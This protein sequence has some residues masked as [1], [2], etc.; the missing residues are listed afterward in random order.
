MKLFYHVI[1]IGLALAGA[2]GFVSMRNKA[3]V[4]H[5]ENLRLRDELATQRAAGDDPAGP[6]AQRN[7][8]LERVQAEARE[9]HKLR[10]EISQLRAGAKEAEKVAMENQR[11]R[12]ATQQ[13][14]T[15]PRTGAAV[16]PAAASQEGFYAK[17]NW[18]FAGYAS[19][20]AA[21]QSIAWAMREGDTKAFLAAVTAEERERMEKE[22][23]NKSEAEVS[24]DAR[25]GTEKVKNIRILERKAISDDEVV[26]SIYAEGG[27]DHVQKMSMKRFGT[28]WKLAGP[29][30]D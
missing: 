7:A 3:A 18:A 29:K 14:Q 17:E 19:P 1:L 27:D 8:E 16:E 30:R 9:V 20:E 4:L 28:E 13:L 12:A 21:L 26:L 15:A 24:A 5:Q 2:A 23:G 25:K 10:G 11:L 22:W 6:K